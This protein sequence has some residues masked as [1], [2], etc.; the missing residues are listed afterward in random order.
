MTTAKPDLP[1][2]GVGSCGSM[3]NPGHI[4]ISSRWYQDTIL[5]EGE[6]DSLGD[7]VLRALR[8]GAVLRGAN[9]SDAVLSGADL[10]G[11]DLSGADLRGADLSGADLSGADLRGADLR[12]AN[13]RG[14]VLSVANLRG[15]VLSDA[16]LS[17]ADLRV[18]NLRDA[19]IPIVENLHQRILADVE[20]RPESFNMRTWHNEC[21]TSHCRAGWAIHLAGAAGY[22]L[23]ERL[24]APAAGAL[25]TLAS[26][27]FLERVPNFYAT[28]EEALADIRACAE[29]ERAQPAPTA[30]GS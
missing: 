10:S 19:V 5:W 24:G 29:R 3:K 4:K 15:A 20:Q 2:R 12:V 11:A 8:A 18:A 13:L 7:A 9:L 6:A 22:A 1:P 16:V 26:C 27:P 25:I 14:A 30:E 28:N 21:G 17:G 23:E